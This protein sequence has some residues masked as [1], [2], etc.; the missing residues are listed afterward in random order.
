MIGSS[1]NFA[2]KNVNKLEK[3]IERNIFLNRCGAI[4]N[5]KLKLNKNRVTIPSPVQFQIDSNQ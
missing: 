1:T 3:K 5:S 4:H 2:R